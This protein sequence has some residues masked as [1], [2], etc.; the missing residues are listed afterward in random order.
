MFYAKPKMA[1]THDAKTF[2]TVTEAVN[3]LNAYN[4]LG[5]DYVQEGYSNDVSKLQAEDFWMLG[6]L[7]G[8][9]GVEFKNN[10]VVGVK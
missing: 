10:K 2:D 1:N 8:P 3:Y 5:P 6:K 9:E 7:V 4:Q